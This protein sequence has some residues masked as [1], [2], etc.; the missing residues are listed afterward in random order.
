MS[1]LIPQVFKVPSQERKFDS[2]RFG[3]GESLRQ[4]QH[5]MKDTGAH[6]EIS[7]A[8]DMTLTFMV[9]GKPSEVAEARRKIQVGFQTQ[10][11]KQMQ[12]PKEMH[13][14]VLGKGGQRLKELESNTGTKISLPNLNDDSEVVTITGPREGI[15]KAEHELKLIVVDQSKKS[16]DTV[17][18]PK[19]YHQFIT[20]A[21]NELLV[22]LCEETGAKVNVPPPSVKKN[23]IIISGEKE[24]VAAAKARIE[25]LHEHLEKTCKTVSVEVPKAQQKY[26]IGSKGST[27][28]AI[29]RD[30]GVYVE[31]PPMDA[32]TDSIML[33]GPHDK[34]GAALA[35][36]YE[37]ANSVRAVVIEA[38]AW[39]H[40]YIIGKKGANIS[41][42]RADSANVHIEL[43][44]NRIKIDGPTE[45]VDKVQEEIQRIVDDYQQNMSFCEM[46][47]N[48]TYMKHLIGKAGTNVNRLQEEL[49]VSI[50]FDESG[51]QNKMRIEGPHEAI[52]VA[53]RE[54]AEKVAR[55]ENEKEKDAIIDHRLFKKLIGAK[56]EKIRDIREKYA[57][58]QIK[59]PNANESS[60]I[61]KIR[62]KKEEVDA[63]YKHLM[64]VVKELQETSFVLEVPIFKK[65]HKYVIGK[66]GANIKKIREDTHTNIDLPAETTDSDVI[67]ITGKKENVYEARTMILKIESELGD[68]V[69]AE[70]N[71]PFDHRQFIIGPSGKFITAIMEECGGVN[72]KF[73]PAE[74]KS[75]VVK[76]RG[77]A[78]DVEKAKQRLLE[79]S[80]KRA[81]QSFTDSVRANPQYHKYLIGKNGATI[82]KIREQTDT[83]II[84]PDTAAEDKETITLIGSEEGVAEAKRQL[85]AMCK[86]IDNTVE[87][88]CEV[89]FKYHRHFTQRRR[90]IIDRISEECGGVQISFP[91]DES[92]VVT[93]K[94]AKDCLEAAKQRILE[95]VYDLENQVTEEAC[96]PVKYHRSLMG[97]RGKHVQD[98]TTRFDV[99]IKFPE[100]EMGPRSMGGGD[101][102][103]DRASV[104][105]DAS[106]APAPTQNGGGGGGDEQVRPVLGDNIRF[107]GAPEKVA[108]AKEALLGL[109]QLVDVPFEAHKSIIGQKG[110]TVRELMNRYDVYIEVPPADEKLDVIKVIGQRECVDAA[111]EAIAKK[112]EE[113]EA[114]RK[115]RE[116]RSF[117]LVIEIDPQYHS[118]IIGRK[119]A[120]INQIRA[121]CDVQIR[122][123]RTNTES[124]ITIQ[125][126]EEATAKAR[127]AI[128]KIVDDLKA[129][130]REEVEVDHR[131][132][133][134]LIGQRGR[135]IRKIM[136]DHK[137]E[138]TFPRSEDANPNIITIIG[139]ED[140]V[141]D[142]KTYILNLEEEIMQDIDDMP[143]K[144]QKL[145]IE[146]VLGNATRE[147][148]VSTGAH[149]KSG[150]GGG[151]KAGFVV[152][153]APWQ[154]PNTSSKDDFPEFG[155]NAAAPAS[156][157]GGASFST[158]WGQPR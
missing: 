44:D 55:L 100:R 151:Q 104:N 11:S 35:M 145:T 138:V 105:G 82:R 75:E 76:L 149:A 143:E 154:A 5:I 110:A 80:E 8:K 129:L 134:R 16:V 52:V 68:I 114:D 88:S 6:I 126:Y 58:V 34:M 9:T 24:H 86:D 152:K 61:V 112:M 72:I 56:G 62:G 113:F 132:F 97:P 32:N 2:E 92:N 146:D 42:L 25:K 137:V 18:V 63:C 115:D 69:E 74:T 121:D 27:I 148:A 19:H 38:P 77:L 29:F 1:L 141:E 133:P 103:A 45:Q 122:L 60:D 98:I 136:E 26:V 23:E 142:C 48:P 158:A 106:Q 119:G 79:L 10:S 59:F 53:Q 95:I 93:L 125:G 41:K 7:S 40:K 85:E 101:R 4:C 90:K 13:R 150:G 78:E 139:A 17:K 28:Q 65:L 108:A 46:E 155:L 123:P 54:M 87:G 31:V 124:A 111:K 51:G 130:V 117:E 64:R 66:G 43:E 37:K 102:D 96:V 71:I 135:S 73:P 70:I 156:A 118:K 49:G 3:E 91:R 140:D 33:R 47:V 99:Q 14:V 67:V 128:Q 131:I 120:V 57:N 21:N 36:V 83:Y 157:E 107:T 50:Y 20:G 30:T 12:V 81:S 15:E 127:D 109:I 84:F 147:A 153:G 94:G 39:I 144:P 22:Q 116:L 89:D